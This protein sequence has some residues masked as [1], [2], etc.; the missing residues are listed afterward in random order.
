MF[1]NENGKPKF[2]KA[3]K[4]E[5]FNYERCDQEMLENSSNDWQDPDQ[6]GKEKTTMC[7]SYYGLISV[8]DKK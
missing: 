4:T 1:N 7:N 5:A 3:E 2:K 6:Q 8:K